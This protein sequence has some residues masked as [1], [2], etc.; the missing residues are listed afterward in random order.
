[1]GA[2]QPLCDNLLQTAVR[3]GQAFT[4]VLSFDLTDDKA[5]PKHATLQS[6]PGAVYVSGS[7]LYMSVVHQKQNSGGRW[8][9]FAPSANEMSEIHKFRIGANPSETA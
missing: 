8:Y 1:D 3:D 5:A 2:A 4:T 6:R 7:A 9:S